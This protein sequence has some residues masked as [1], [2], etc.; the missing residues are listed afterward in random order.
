MNDQDFIDLVIK[1]RTSQRH[2]F[3]YKDIESLQR[4][5]K[6]EREV[7]KAIDSRCAPRA[8]KSL[9]DRMEIDQ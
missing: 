7:D 6:L 8:A 2:W 1:M 5:K 9:F 3:K 4:A